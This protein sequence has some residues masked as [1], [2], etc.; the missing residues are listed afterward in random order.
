MVT[1][2]GEVPLVLCATTK[3]FAPKT[4]AEFI[5]LGEGQSRQGALRQ[6]RRR[7]QQSLRHR[8][9]RA[10]GRHQDDPHPEQGRRRGDHQRLVT[11]DAQVVFINAASSAGVIKGGHDAGCWR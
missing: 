6:R 2:L 9:L 3:D 11:G 7:Q 5:A 10:V 4:Y 1:R 8:G